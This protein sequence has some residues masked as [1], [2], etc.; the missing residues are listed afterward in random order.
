MNEQFIDVKN[1]FKM[2]NRIWTE[3][4]TRTLIQYSYEQQVAEDID[5]NEDMIN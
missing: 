4:L 5:Y 1:Y 3:G 2:D